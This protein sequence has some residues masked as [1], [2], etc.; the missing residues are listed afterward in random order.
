MLT[1]DVVWP[2]DADMQLCNLCQD[3]STV[4]ELKMA[5]D[6]IRH[7]VANTILYVICFDWL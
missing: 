5:Q 7:H 6:L 3:D 1:V 2:W 4:S